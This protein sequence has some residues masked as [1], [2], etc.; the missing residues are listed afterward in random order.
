MIQLF[1]DGKPVQ[2]KS[3]TKI[4]LTLENSFFS[5][6]SE[7]TYEVELPLALKDTRVFWSD[8]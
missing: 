4:K 2:I 3:T 1:L 7:Y 5:T 8:G 6:G